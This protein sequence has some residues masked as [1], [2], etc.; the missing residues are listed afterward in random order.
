MGADRVD[1]ARRWKAM[2]AASGKL[3][4]GPTGD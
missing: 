2:T 1:P 3:V 4:K